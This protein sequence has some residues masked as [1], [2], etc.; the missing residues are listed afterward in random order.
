MTRKPTRS[1]GSSDS[2]RQKARKQE[3]AQPDVPPLDSD[4]DDDDLEA[5][6]PPPPASIEE[7]YSKQ[8]RQINYNKLDLAVLTIRTQIRKTIN[9]RPEFQRRDRWKNDRRSRFIESIIMNVPLPP[10]FLGEEEYGKYSVLD[11]RQRLTAVY[12]FLR[13]RYRLRGLKV[14]KKL[15]GLKYEDLQ[16]EGIASFLERRFIPAVVIARESSP[17][18]KYDVFDRLNTGGVTANPMEVRNA[19]FPG[20][21]NE[22]LHELSGLP[23][24]RKLW[25]IPVPEGDD[26]A[27][28][29]KNG[30]YET[31]TDLEIVLR[32]FA[33]AGADLDGSS[34]KE[35]LSNYMAAR[36]RE[37]AKDETLADADRRSFVR[38]IEN[39]AS[40]LGMGAFRRVS[41]KAKPKDG[42][43]PRPQLS[44]PYADALM[45]AFAD[46]QSDVFTPAVRA[47]AKQAIEELEYVDDFRT[48]VEKGTNSERAI[49]TRVSLARSAVR[50]AVK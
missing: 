3:P 32:F 5:P 28:L 43:P 46:H 12:H 2:P 47:K 44:R 29:K 40:V 16:R 35:H 8:M 1:D 38:A 17:E 26:L 31:M 27:A 18:V 9:L 20:K 4:D 23:L 10:V 22:L 48:A 45:L 41:S 24:F 11:G 19:I 49:Q 37:Y 15:N 30:Y 33:L 42:K 50:R 36:T 6:T 39:C 34:F 7:Q 13:N 25:G 14:W 21:F